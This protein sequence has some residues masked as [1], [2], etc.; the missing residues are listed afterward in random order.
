MAT[1]LI[2]IA[3]KDGAV[4]HG[5]VM[6]LRTLGEELGIGAPALDLM[7]EKTK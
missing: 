2:H 6:R 4:S 7:I 3:R 5:R 1:G